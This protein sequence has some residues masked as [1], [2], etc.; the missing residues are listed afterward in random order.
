MMDYVYRLLKEHP[1]SHERWIGL[2][3]ERLVKAPDGHFL[4]YKPHLQGLLEAL[5]AQKGWAVDYEDSGNFLGL[6]KG[7][8]TISL[9]PGSQFEVSVSPQKTIFDIKKRQSEIDA[10]I[11]S[12]PI[13]QGWKWVSTGINPHDVALDRGL[14]PS[15]RYALMNQYFETHGTR[16]R[17]M[18]RLTTGL[19]INLDFADEAEGVDMLRLA[20]Y[21]CPFFSA[22]FSNSPF[23]MGAR[24][25]ALSERQLVWKEMDPL[26][27]GFLPFIFEK[28]FSLKKYAEHV[29]SVPLMYAYD[30]NGKVWDPQGKS[31]SD[32]PENLAQKNAL[33]ALRQLFTHVRL[34]PCC[35][36]I[37]YL[38]EQEEN[39]RYAATALS[40]GLLYDEANRAALL[41]RFQQ[42]GLE[43]MILLTDVG[44]VKGLQVKTIHDVCSGLKNLA[45]EGLKRRGFGEEK[46]LAP[47]EEMLQSKKTPADMQI[48]KNSWE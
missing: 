4:H 8:D 32:M 44:A 38:D 2:E 13:A 35:V 43:E 22:M 30:E 16:G 6:K 25:V 41:E 47:V 36:E 42:M 14:L 24:S 31:L 21:L 12:L 5:V 26:R 34:K 20:Y 45:E 17:D 15:P 46:F 33:G 1:R 19:Q 28:D 40:V 7:L 48:E 23:Y 9:E 3:V 39:M 37:R 11:M 10:E 27:S 18:M 29:S